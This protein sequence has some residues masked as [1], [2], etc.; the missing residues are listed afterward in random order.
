MADKNISEAFTAGTQIQTLYKT[1]GTSYETQLADA[2]STSIIL[3]GVM[4]SGLTL[5]SAFVLFAGAII[6]ILR[7][8]ALSVL[9]ILG[10]LAFVGMILPK[11]SQ[12]ASQ[13]WEQLI[14]QALL[15]PAFL[16]MLLLTVSTIS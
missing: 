14:K 16:F 10:P 11:T 4:G 5:I 8:V 1:K 2:K 9:L 6:F 15:A 3:I 12:Y 13:W 7:D